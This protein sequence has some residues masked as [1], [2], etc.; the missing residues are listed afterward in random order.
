MSTMRR[1]FA[2]RSKI[3]SVFV[4]VRRQVRGLRHERAQDRHH[5]RRAHVL[6]LEHHR[7][8]FVVERLRRDFAGDRDRQLPRIRVAGTFDHAV[9]FVGGE[10]MDVRIASSRA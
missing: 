4:R 7:D 10:L 1:A 8:L 3:T 6:R 9:R 5:V 2:A